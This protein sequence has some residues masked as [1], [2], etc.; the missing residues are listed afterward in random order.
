[1]NKLTST[2]TQLPY[3]YYSLPFC[4][5]DNVE[6]VAENLGEVLRGDRI[7]NSHYELKMRVE[8][9]CKIL[10]RKELTGAEAKLFSVR[11]EED[12]RVHWV[13]DNLPSATKYVDETV[14]SKPV[15]IY[16][17]GFPLGFK[18]SAD[19]PG[20]KE[21]VGYLNNH[22]L[23]TIKYHTDESFEGARIV[24]F[25]IEPSSIKHS[26]SGAWKNGDT[27]LATCG[28]SAPSTPLALDKPGEVVFTYDVKWEYSEV[29]WASRWD[30]Y[31]L[32]GDEQ[33]HWFSIVNSLM[34]VLFLSGMV[35]MIMMRTLHRDFNRCAATPRNSSANAIRPRNSAQFFRRRPRPPLRYNAIEASDEMEEETGWKLV[36]G[37]VFRPPALPMLL[38]VFVGTGVQTLAMSIITMCFAVLGFLSPANRGGL[39]TAMLLLFVFMGVPAGYS[40]A[41]LHKSLKG[42]DWKK[43]IVLTSWYCAQ[44]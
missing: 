30:T 15:T 38:S 22:L 10:C 18:G 42:T 19:I 41:F 28:G 27:Q 2:K 8:E 21:G 29:K 39:M 40:S 7:M 36:H 14:P 44:F 25:E 16:D 34:I 12:Y 13:M 6:N 37:D 5:P 24:G 3:E 11:I 9:T 17:L 4:Q 1:M 31:L 33:I 20:T 43:N 23:I 35:A 26:Y 32:I